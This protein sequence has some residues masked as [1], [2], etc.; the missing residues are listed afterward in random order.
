MSEKLRK[1]LLG[2]IFLGLLI[3]TVISV[4]YAYYV[5]TPDEKYELST[6]FNIPSC[7]QVTLEEF[8]DTISVS[9]DYSAPIQDER[10]LNSSDEIRSNY[11]YSFRVVNNC[12]N[13]MEIVLSFAPTSNN[14]MPISAVK[15]LLVEGTNEPETTTTDTT[16]YTGGYLLKDN[17]V[18]QLTDQII[19]D[20]KL[21]TGKTVDLGFE[22]YYSPSSSS[23]ESQR[24]I[25]IPT[26]S[27]KIFDLY[28]WIDYYEGDKTHTGANNNA[29]INKK[30]EGVII[31][32]NYSNVVN[33][34]EYIDYV[35]PTYYYAFISYDEYTA[36]GYPTTTT[37]YTTIGKKVFVRDDTPE[38]TTREVCI[39][40]TEGNPGLHCLKNN[41]WEVEQA[42]IQEVFSD[43]SCGV[44]SSSVGCNASDFSCGVISGGNVYCY[45]YSTYESCYVYSNG[46]V[47][48][49]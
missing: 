13:D 47:D 5:I 33:N 48:C 43:I 12:S 24:T 28:L 19:S 30:L 14:I 22:M 7:A 29:T 4:S 31:I 49:V 16:G 37:D 20:T 32:S 23:L 3:S 15:Y 27:G 26:E 8:E 25:T 11:R 39:L 1:I 10:L 46:N 45:D 41:N 44:D 36:N 21:N 34:D 17:N 35:D 18:K 6:N 9:G 42:H 2:V 40:R 38:E